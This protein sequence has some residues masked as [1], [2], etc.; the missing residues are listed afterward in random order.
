[1]RR[2]AE[3][4]LARVLAIFVAGVIAGVQIALYLFDLYDDGIADFRS[5]LIGLILLVSGLIFA[6]RSFRPPGN[7][8]Q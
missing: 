4:S 6:L 2:R 1:M 7:L 8:R 5:F 3:L